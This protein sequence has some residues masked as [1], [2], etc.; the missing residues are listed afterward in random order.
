VVLA[1]G[2]QSNALKRIQ[3]KSQKPVDERV[4][5]SHNLASLLSRTQRCV[6]LTKVSEQLL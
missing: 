4:K 2:I 1:A 3:K 5:A 6:M